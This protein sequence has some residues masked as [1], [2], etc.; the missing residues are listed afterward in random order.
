MKAF[1]M[2][3][4]LA[5]LTGA[6]WFAIVVAWQVNDVQPSGSDLALYLGGLPLLAIGAV[7]LVRYGLRQRR[8]RAAERAAAPASAARGTAEPGEH[9]APAVAMCCICMPPPCTWPS[10]RVPRRP[11][12]ICSSPSGRGCIRV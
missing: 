7:L 10:A 12:R 1:K 5:L 2:I 11:R 3:L 4:L 8:E 6:I 9:D